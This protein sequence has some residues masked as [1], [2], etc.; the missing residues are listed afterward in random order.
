MYS[1]DVTFYDLNGKQ[2]TEKLHFSLTTVE[3]ARLSAKL[4]PD[5]KDLKD[6]LVDVITGGD[7]FKLISLVADIM[8]AAYGTKSTDGLRFV[9]NA[10]L[11]ADFENS[12]A[13]AEY[14]DLALTDQEEGNRFVSGVFED[15]RVQKA[16]R[17]KLG[18]V[19]PITP[20]SDY[21]PVTS[22]ATLDDLISKAS[23]GS[24]IDPEDLRR[25]LESQNK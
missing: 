1:K 9:K 24:K 18:T 17:E 4:S 10:E 16:G 3:I 6:Y 7:N 2:Q 22:R 25:L 8:L 19:A 13:F 11:T 5:G 12:V 21:Q 23:E 20:I 14:L 15:S